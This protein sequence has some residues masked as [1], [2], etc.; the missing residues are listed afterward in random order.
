MKL[1]G[2]LVNGCYQAKH[3]QG[4]AKNLLDFKEMQ[5]Q[6]GVILVDMEAYKQVNVNPANPT[7]ADLDSSEKL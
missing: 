7:I 1:Q 4:L 3:A 2:A 6:V 5:D